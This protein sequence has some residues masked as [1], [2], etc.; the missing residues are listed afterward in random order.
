MTTTTTTTS[1]PCPCPPRIK[2]L[3]STLPTEGAI[4]FSFL[5]TIIQPLTDLCKSI[6]G[7]K[8][9]CHTYNQNLD[10]PI[11]DLSDAVLSLCH[12]ACTAYDLLDE[13]LGGNGTGAGTGTATATPTGTATSPLT[14]TKSPMALGRLA[15]QDEE[16][17]LLARQ[18]VYAVLT[19]LSALLR[20]VY[21]RGKE[22]A[23]GSPVP[24]GTA[25]APARGD[26]DL[27]MSSGARPGLYGRE[28]DGPTELQE[29]SELRQDPAQL[30]HQ[31]EGTLRW[32]RFTSTGYL[33]TKLLQIGSRPK[34]LPPGPATELIW[35]NLKQVNMLF[36]QYQYTKWAKT[37]G[38]VYTV[39]LG[40]TAHVV[41]SGLQE[42]RD[43]FIKQGANSQ[44]RPPSRFQLLM[45]D[46]Y[47][48]GLMNGEK[49]RHAR[50]MW[51]TVLNGSAAKQ[52]LPYQELETRQLLFDLLQAPNEW[53]DHIERYSNSVAMTMDLSETGVR[54]AFLDFWPFLWKIPQWFFPI[55]EQARAI[56]AK[57]RDLIW[58]NYSDVRQRTTKGEALPSFNHAIQEKLKQGWPGVSEIEGAEI[59]HHLL[60]GT[61]DTTASSLINWVAAMCLNP[62]AQ[63][64]AQEEIDRVVGPDRLPTD[65]DAERLPYTRQVIQESQRWITAVHLSLPRAANGPV[66]WNGYE[67]AEGTG[68][69]MN[70][71]AIHNDPSLFPEPHEFRPERW[72]GKPNASY[73]GD[74]QLLFTFGA[75]RRICP[76]QHLAERSLFLVISH[77]L[78]GFNTM[79]ATDEQGKKIPINKDDLR[80]G[81]IVCLNPFSAHI[82][83]RS[84]KHA[85]LIRETWMEELEVSLNQSQ[86]WK[87]TPEGI[88]RLIDRVGK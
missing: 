26:I 3:S 64:K 40:D 34:S 52:Y 43:V 29:M 45:R 60:T 76:G 9:P 16:E 56:A 14:C 58:R 10:A 42:T 77:W 80:P 21:I 85:K 27:G 39:M 78:W 70:S 6:E 63:K 71:Y 86:Q 61:T 68:L 35:G 62:E 11:V 82:T 24:S 41:V 33:A 12:A 37:Y 67:I 15:L 46:G 79:Q 44:A 66:R 28:W 88:S 47:F 51:Q 38:P 17:T 83:P 2:Q 30:H 48:P 18:V 13:E 4:D 7:C 81:F 73:N 8:H 75:G 50:K 32:T 84:P 57:H 87:A 36:P 53:R 74:G 31:N 19:S 59:G 49:W 22:A 1:N 25:A 72:E 55:C 20:D 54:G 5:T 65:D 23:G 69:I